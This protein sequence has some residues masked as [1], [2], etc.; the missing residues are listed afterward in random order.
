MSFNLLQQ[1]A[2]ACPQR[3]HLFSTISV[4]ISGASAALLSALVLSACSVFPWESDTPELAAEAEPTTEHL[5]LLDSSRID[6][7]LV[8][9]TLQTPALSEPTRVQILLP[10]RYD[11]TPATRYPVVYLLQ[12]AVDDYTAW[13]REGNAEALTAGYP[14]II[15][16]PDAGKDGFYSDWYNGGAFGPPE[17]ETY[18]IHLL[19]PWIDA[20]YRTIAARRGRAVGGVS[21]GGFGALSYAARHPDLFAAVLSFSGLVNSN[22][23]AGQS[24]IPDQVFGPRA[25]Q[26]VRWRGHNPWDLAGN[27][28]G[29]D[30][31]LY[32]R[33]GLPGKDWVGIDPTEIIVH[34]QS[35]ELHE[36]LLAENVPHH[37]EYQGAGAHKWPTWQDDLS[38]ALLSLATVFSDPPAEPSPVS[39]KTIETDYRIY[40]WHVV[41]ERPALEFSELTNADAHGFSLS[42]SGIGVVTTPPIYTPHAKFVLTL[43]AGDGP[44]ASTLHSTANGRLNIRVP[45]GPANPDQQYTRVAK[46][47]EATKTNVVTVTIEPATARAETEHPTANP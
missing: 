22:S 1:Q 42:G 36:Q 14:M 39:F 37:W 47:S 2:A 21:M 3:F 7:R 31:S 26:E 6:A 33:D 34:R 18:H 10:E 46:D 35:V 12:G 19:I 40:G 43:N 28:R 8:A 45:L 38:R 15:V 11:S 24:I 17:W 25:T 29:M 9:L 41:L 32:T 16:M 20:H 5:K 4:Q 23:L 30:V 13:I 27:L 44:R